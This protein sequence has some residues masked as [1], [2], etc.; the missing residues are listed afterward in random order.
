MS[1]NLCELRG[2]YRCPCHKYIIQGDYKS[3]ENTIPPDTWLIK[4]L[5]AV[6][7]GDKQNIRRSLGK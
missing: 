1:A 3:G 5:D 6:I 4:D 2:P 7:T